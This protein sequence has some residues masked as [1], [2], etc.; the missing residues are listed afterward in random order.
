MKNKN[1]NP[2]ANIIPNS[3]KD[4]A[5]S[6]KSEEVQDV[7]WVSPDVY[8]NKTTSVL[9]FLAGL[10]VNKPKPGNMAKHIHKL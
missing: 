1:K 9:I 2:R 5:F 10:F 6:L 8:A 3:K 4:W 7:C